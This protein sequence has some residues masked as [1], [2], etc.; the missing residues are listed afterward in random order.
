[1]SV[2][3]TLYPERATKD[4]LCRLVRARGYT[5]CT[6][7]W[8]WPAGSSNFH[9]FEETDFKSI[10][11]VEATVF[12][13]REGKPDYAAGCDWALHTRTRASSSTYDR[14]EQNELIREARRR[15]GGSFY[16]DW[17]GKNRYT[18]VPVETK[19]PAGRGIFLVY[20][21]V[22]RQVKM[23]ELA[24]PQPWAVTPDGQPAPDFMSAFDPSRVLNNAL[25]P[26][27]VAAIEHFFGQA[28][29]ILV[30]YDVDAQRHLLEQ[31]RKVELPQVVAVSNG[32]LAVEDIVADWYSFQNLSAIHNAFSEWLGIDF[33]SL[34]RARRRLGRRVAFLDEHMQRLI[35]CRHGLVHRFEFDYDIDRDGMKTLLQTVVA[36]IDAFVDFL[37]TER[38][39]Q[40]RDD[41]P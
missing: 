28:F 1:M 17:H 7:L 9:W 32:E 38:G 3:I 14:A 29:R 18:P 16:N 11:G 20:E 26:F 36:V 35:D 2:E 34:L 23:V 31:S 8:D 27:A 33:W 24:L 40:V 22:T 19:T 39:I 25:V 41:S 30:Q 15:Y 4:D 12:P 6:H 10:D 21:F 5:K 37:E 13:P